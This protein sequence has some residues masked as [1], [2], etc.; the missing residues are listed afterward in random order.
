MTP[1]TEEK[2]R[3]S[4]ETLHNK[5]SHGHKIR[6]QQGWER[7]VNLDRG[8]KTCPRAKAVTAYAES[9]QEVLLNEEQR[10]FKFNPTPLSTKKKPIYA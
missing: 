2:L 3:S 5:V 6:G 9:M 1:E 7:D 8:Y 10:A 4:I